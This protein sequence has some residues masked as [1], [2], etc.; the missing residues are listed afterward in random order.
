MA[1]LAACIAST[2]NP[3]RESESK[4]CLVRHERCR[5]GAVMP[6]RVRDNDSSQLYQHLHSDSMAT[7]TGFHRFFIWLTSHWLKGYEHVC[8]VYAR[9]LLGCWKAIENGSD[10]SLIDGGACSGH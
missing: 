9:S 3:S 7:D 2:Q 10:G 1:T 4:S 8:V 5:L 6:R